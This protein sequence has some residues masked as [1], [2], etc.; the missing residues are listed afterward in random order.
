M[1][2]FRKRFL[3]EIL[4]FEYIICMGLLRSYVGYN[5]IW[6]I[7]LIVLFLT[8]FLSKKIYRSMLFEFYVKSPFF[9][10]VIFLG[11]ISIMLG[12]NNQYL[13]SNIARW[14]EV[15]L[16]LCI[17]IMLAGNEKFD[18][19]KVMVNHFYFLNLFWIINLIVLAIQLTGTGFMVK[20]EWL[21]YNR[22]YLDHCSGLF[23]G[24]GTHKLSCFAIFMLVYNLYV[25]D[26][27]GTRYRKK[28]IYIYTFATQLWM[29]Y[30]SSKND[31][32]TFFMLLPYFLVVYFILRN[33]DR[34]NDIRRALLWA[35]KIAGTLTVVVIIAVV[36]LSNFT[37]IW[38]YINE[39][40]LQSAL[41]LATQGKSGSVGSIER[42]TIA[43][44]AI[45]Q[46][47]GLFFGDGLGAAALSEGVSGHY[48]G[49]IHFSMSSIGTLITLGGVWFYIS[50]CLIYT[51]A[52]SR[53]IKNK[54]SS[55]LC[56]F[57]CLISLVSLSVYTPI[58]ETEIG[59][60]WLCFTFVMCGK[61]QK[62]KSVKLLY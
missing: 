49:Y 51:K 46:G 37:E 7:L 19:R 33:L 21:E 30:L 11:L 25:A 31:N 14:L 3:L 1:L 39:T 38:E 50:Y 55:I 2:K 58:F 54:K 8:L 26:E 4:T 42:L 59:M 32:K 18:I 62:I 45:S 35:V 17:V 13:F 10:S 24:S 20:D 5:N 16:I 60:L 47:K 57:I 23:G 56:D 52:F 9:W 29:I 22:L 53:F 6:R 41:T 48:R 27:A 61:G 36:V 12:S 34:I 28:A 15:Q 44:D 43:T 40:V